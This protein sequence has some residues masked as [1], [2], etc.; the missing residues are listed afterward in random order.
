MPTANVGLVAGEA[1]IVN[2]SCEGGGRSPEITIQSLTA[3]GALGVPVDPDSV[4]ARIEVT[5]EIDRN[6]GNLT[7]Y[8]LAAR[9]TITDIWYEIDTQTFGQGTAEGPAAQQG[10]ELT[11]ISSWNTDHNR[12]RMGT[13]TFRSATALGGPYEPIAADADRPYHPIQLNGGYEL[14][15]RVTSS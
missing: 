10:D 7:A 11:I 4:A 1:E 12:D 3:G 2:F 6:D 15:A 14:V 13:T 8:L 5:V 9:D